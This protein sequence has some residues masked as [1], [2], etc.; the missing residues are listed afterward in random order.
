MENLEIWYVIGHWCGFQDG[1]FVCAARGAYYDSL[2]QCKKF[3]FAML[4][5]L[6]EH[7]L[8]VGVTDPTILEAECRLAQEAAT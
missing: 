1:Q 3:E 7:A 4:F 2:E 5:G 6:F 8:S